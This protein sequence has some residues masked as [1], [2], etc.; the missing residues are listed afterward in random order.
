MGRRAGIKNL[1]HIPEE[2]RSTHKSITLSNR[3]W[4]YLG[5]KPGQ[6]AAEILREWIARHTPLEEQ[7]PSKES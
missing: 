3:E 7:E 1:T 6:K 4:A 2:L 5:D